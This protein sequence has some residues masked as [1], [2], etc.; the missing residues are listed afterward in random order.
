MENKLWRVAPG[1]LAVCWLAPALAEDP[2]GASLE[3]LLATEV[4][5]ASKG[6]QLISE[7]PANVTVISAEEIRRYGYRTLIDALVRV[8]GVFAS[9]MPHGSA[10]AVRGSNANQSADWGS[11]I[12]LMV[13]GHRVNDGMYDQA[14][15]GYDSLVDIEAVERIEFIKGPGSTLYGGNALYGVVNVITRRGRAG[16]EAEWWSQ[17]T[18]GA[19]SFG[20]TLG[21]AVDGGPQWRLSA[22]RRANPMYTGRVDG[23]PQGDMGTY[24]ESID[25][26]EQSEQASLTVDAGAFRVVALASRWRPDTAGGRTMGGDGETYPVRADGDNSQYLLGASGRWSLGGQTE[27]AAQ[28]S[29]GQSRR[30]FTEGWEEP[31]HVPWQANWHAASR[32][33][34]GELRLASEAFDRQRVSAGVEWRRDFLREYADHYLAGQTELP[35]WQSR[36]S[37]DSVGVYLQ[38]EVALAERWALTVGGRLDKV[39]GYGNEFSPRL[40]LVWAPSAATT[41][42]LI[43]AEAFRPPNSYEYD[44]TLKEDGQLL[45][46]ARPGLER[47]KSKELSLEYRQGAFAGSAALFAN[48]NLGML[49]YLGGGETINQPEIRTR[50]IEL[51]ASWRALSGLGGYANLAWQ[52][53]RDAEGKRPSGTP[54]WVASAGVD[55]A[56]ADGRYLAA[57]EWQAL[58][59][60]EL[61]GHQERVPGFGVANVRLAA[62]PWHKALEWSLQVQNLTGRHYLQPSQGT[63]AAARGRTAWLG[64]RYTP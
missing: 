48:R 17:A 16:G 50:G 32:W 49:T 59:A 7:A 35:V 2:A 29:L 34:G 37:R 13:D 64:V 14:L 24:S 8:P 52:R 1:L 60:V 30:A 22:A 63:L 23:R 44:P 58:S 10:L 12:L 26:S 46:L 41:V 20:A 56:S 19:A 27:L 4:V 11:R 51:S 53:S 33:S 15:F 25:F 3:D 18:P 38:D 40:A 36:S 62:R 55:A 6:R 57:L 61:F 54:E 39:T 9:H 5:G 47:V 43:H 31:G 28:L 42:K 45:P 21:G